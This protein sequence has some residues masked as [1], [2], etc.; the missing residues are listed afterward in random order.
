MASSS[1]AFLAIV[2]CAEYDP[3]LIL[4][5]YLFNQFRFSSCEYVSKS[6]LLLSISVSAPWISHAC[7][8][9]EFLF[10]CDVDGFGPNLSAWGS[11][12]WTAI[13]DFL[14]L[15]LCFS[16]SHSPHC[17]STVDHSLTSIHLFPSLF[18]LHLILISLLWTCSLQ[19]TMFSSP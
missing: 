14:F 10:L 3:L 7:V 18:H 8:Q 12:I 11:V 9:A 16:L 19:I 1:S 13:R 5:V 15:T 17:H 6:S 4:I 2:K